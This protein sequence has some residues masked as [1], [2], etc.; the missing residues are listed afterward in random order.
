MA[1][2][3]YRSTFDCLSRREIEITLLLATGLSNKEL[4]RRLNLAE[5]TIKI[6][7]HN[8]YKKL[9]ISNRTE[10]AGLALRD[11]LSGETMP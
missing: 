7:L 9:G 3:K 1:N 6:H 10:L 8:V 2:Q 4:G 5:G 11:R